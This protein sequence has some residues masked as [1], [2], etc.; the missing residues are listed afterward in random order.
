[1]N[2]DK[3]RIYASLGDGKLVATLT[4]KNFDSEIDPEIATPLSILLKD[5]YEML[6][7]K[8]NV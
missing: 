6:E 8:K 1:M 2:D 4:Y 5:Y 7:E 3:I